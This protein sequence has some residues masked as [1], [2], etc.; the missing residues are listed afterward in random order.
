MSD[1]ELLSVIVP[2]YN[3]AR[4]VVPCLEAIRTNSKMPDELLV[5]DDASTDLTARLAEAIADRVIRINENQ[6]R[7]EARIR[8]LREAQGKVLTAI[9]SDIL[10]PPAALE[11][12]SSFFADHPEA[13]AITGRLAKDAG[14]G[15]FSRYKNLYMYFIFG[16]LNQRVTFLFGS[17]CAVRKAALDCLPEQF[18]YL[19]LG[20][21]TQLGALLAAAGKKIYFLPDLQ[22]RHL[23]EYT[24]VSFFKN[25]FLIPF[26]WAQMFCRSAWC[27]LF[28]R[29]PGYFHAPSWQLGSLILSPLILLL[30]FLSIP[31]I[32]LRPALGCGAALWLLLNAPFLLF[33]AEERGLSFAVFSVV[34]TFADQLTMAAGI[35]CGLLTASLKYLSPLART[36]EK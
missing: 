24:P 8:G 20:E 21:D 28:S 16:C 30:V 29:R 12:I 7:A 18:Q 19:P 33:L 25:D 9:D 14:N 22:V 2:A 23:K 32:Y 17:I 36:A 31:F 3:A 1:R 26:Y 11:R 6:G 27:Q 4:T 5:V 35:G 15:F 34:V 10:V 13:D